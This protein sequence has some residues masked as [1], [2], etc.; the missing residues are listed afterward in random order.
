MKGHMTLLVAVLDKMYNASEMD[1]FQAAFLRAIGEVAPDVRA[2]IIDKLRE[3]Q[4]VG[5][6]THLG[7]QQPQS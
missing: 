5:P 7:G 6:F 4:P 3:R 1:A 2:A